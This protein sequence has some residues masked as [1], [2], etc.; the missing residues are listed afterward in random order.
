MRG[1]AK[2]RPG[3]ERRDPRGTR[4]A[5]LRAGASLFAERGFDGVSV[6]D[7]ADRA[8]VNKALISYHFGGKRALYAGI[9]ESAF[10]SMAERLHAIERDAADAREAL[11]GFLAAFEQ[12]TR[13]QPGF[14]TLFVREVVSTGIEPSVVPHLLEI[15]GVSRR[16]AERGAREG[17]F[18]RIDPLL[19]HF[20]LVGSVAFFF[21]TEPARNKAVAEGRIPFTMPEPKAFLRYLE[22]LTVQGLAPLPRRTASP[23]GLPLRGQAS[24]RD[25]T[26]RKG[27]RA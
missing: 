20:G 1:K 21:A 11:R 18:R 16:L 22:Q 24:R 23:A 7:V 27:A 17:L 2:R 26:R 10:A 3:H 12:A 9:L 19:L 14:P 15:I 13:E 25:N 5:L 8:G 6:E 4:Q